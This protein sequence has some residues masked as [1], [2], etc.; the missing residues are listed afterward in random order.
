MYS[1][2]EDTLH[3]SHCSVDS[4]RAVF[5]GEYAFIYD[6]SGLADEQET[7]KSI[8]EVSLTSGDKINVFSI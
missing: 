8:I 6:G 2:S 1:P 4:I 5:Q 3:I 7:T